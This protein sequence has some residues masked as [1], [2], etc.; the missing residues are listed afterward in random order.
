MNVDRRTA[1]AL[2]LSSALWNGPQVWDYVDPGTMDEGYRQV[3]FAMKALA[4]AHK[5]VNHETLTA[6]CARRGVTMGIDRWAMHP[7]PAEDAGTAYA[8]ATARVRLEQTLLRASQQLAAGADHRDI[9]DDVAGLLKTLD[10]AAL[11]DPTDG[12]AW[13]E[14]HSVQRA[15]EDWV[16]PGLLARGERLVLTG[17][18][19]H[20][21]STLV[22]QLVLGAAF[23]VSPLDGHETFRP[24]RVLILDV[25]NTEYQI[26]EQYRRFGAAYW[27]RSDLDGSPDVLLLRNRYID[28]TKPGDRQHLA[29]AANTY[30]PDLLYLGSGYRLADGTQEHRVVANS[31]Q[32]TVDQIRA[33][34]GCAVVL[35]THA[36]HGFQ[37]DRN[38]WRPDGSS[39]WLR[40][41]E[42][43]YGMEPLK[44]RAG[45][46]VRL[47][48]WR[49]DRVTGRD[50][51]DGL[52]SGG[53]LP[54][55]PVE[56]A[57]IEM[58]TR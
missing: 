19:G 8:E 15:A 32:Q 33:D 18:E 42:F 45:R 27:R 6:E 46:L 9:A 43:G 38:G 16:L 53:I 55:L 30:K 17:M 20:G 4:D 26:A 54:W 37:N 40:W 25:E 49:G 11:G 2:V 39:Y 24:Q 34:V 21:K 23:G 12:R 5:V 31:I 3:A 44:P 10:R 47:R 29:R 51:P 50:W 48:Q 28:L 1:Q 56:D 58:A 52:R 22:Y 36:G 14:M 7:I 57:E 13:D 35:E 41:P